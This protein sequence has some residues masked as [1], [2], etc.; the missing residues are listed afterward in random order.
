M[1]ITFLNPIFKKSISRSC[2]YPVPK[3][4]L[5]LVKVDPKPNLNPFF[6]DKS[7]IEYYL[8]FIAGIMPYKNKDIVNALDLN[9]KAN[10]GRSLA[11]NT[12]L[13]VLQ[14]NNYD[15]NKIFKLDIEDFIEISKIFY[16]YIK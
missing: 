14:D 9:L 12:I 6:K 5:S 10:F 16:E 11:K 1:S 7:S 15:N 3:I 4:E 2:F 13:R 8:K